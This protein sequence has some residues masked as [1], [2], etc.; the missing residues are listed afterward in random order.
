M[1]PNLFAKKVLKSVAKNKAIIIV[2]SG[3]RVYW[4]INRLSPSLGMF[5]S[6]RQ[7]QKVQKELEIEIVGRLGVR[8]EN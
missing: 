3:W 5:L 6:Q 4:W 7:F 2:P 1:D 8:P